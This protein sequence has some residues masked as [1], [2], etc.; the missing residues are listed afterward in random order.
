MKSG[1]IQQQESNN[2]AASS[3]K[4]QSDTFSAEKKA[5]AQAQARQTVTSTGI[6][7]QE[8]HIAS[9]TQSNYTITKN[10]IS[11]T[12]SSMI[13]SSQVIICLL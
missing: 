8:K 6:F 3:I 11:S 9:T 13:S 10:G 5:M 2:V 12:G 7:N 1:D 4:V